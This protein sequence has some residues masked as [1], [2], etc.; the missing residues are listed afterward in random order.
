MSPL[1]AL[2]SSPRAYLCSLLACVLPFASL[3]QDKP[4]APPS[5]P[6]PAAAPAA[7]PAKPVP[8]RAP[9]AGLNSETAVA[10]GEISPVP[11]GTSHQDLVDRRDS[12]EG[13]I[14]YGKN[15][16]DAA[17]KRVEILQ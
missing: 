7:D 8:F 10:P 3:A 14:R 11:T 9:A 2:K 4:E 1:A 6:A 15:K 17:R 12:L 5:A 16:I 13:D